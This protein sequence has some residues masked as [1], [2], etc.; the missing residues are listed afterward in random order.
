MVIFSI[1][2]TVDRSVAKIVSFVKLLEGM[3]GIMSMNTHLK[4]VLG[5]R[6]VFDLD[7]YLLWI[8]DMMFIMGQD[9]P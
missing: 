9:L 8:S 3:A 5:F 2:S 1:P 6:G 4:G 7:F